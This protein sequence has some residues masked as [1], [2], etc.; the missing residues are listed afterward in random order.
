MR[1]ADDVDAGDR[2]EAHRGPGEAAHLR[3]AVGQGDDVAASRGGAVVEERVEVGEVRGEQ[4]DGRCA[5]VEHRGASGLDVGDERGAGGVG[6]RDA[7]V[8]EP[9]HEVEAGDVDGGVAPVAAGR[10]LGGAE[11]VAPVPGAQGRRCYTETPR[12]GRDREAGRRDVR[13]AGSALGQDHDV[14]IVGGNQ[15]RGQ[16]KRARTAPGPGRAGGPGS[17]AAPRAAGRPARS[18]LDVRCPAGC[19]G[20]E[21]TVQVTAL[22]QHRDGRDGFLREAGIQERTRR[23]STGDGA[24]ARDVAQVT[25]SLQKLFKFEC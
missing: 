23:R 25:A 7:R 18:G 10:P 13:C 8:D 11:P 14:L 15:V 22:S 3:G 19:R 17:A 5:A 24:G 21:R 9:T 12:D 20:R 4:L 6:R 1:V 16:P 2:V